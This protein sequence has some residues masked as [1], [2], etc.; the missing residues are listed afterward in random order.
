MRG[1]IVSRQSRNTFPQAAQQLAFWRNHA[2]VWQ[3]QRLG[4]IAP[5]HDSSLH[6]HKAFEQ[7]T[8]MFF[9][10]GEQLT[11]Q[12]LRLLSKQDRRELWPWI[13]LPD[14]LDMSIAE[15][16]RNADGGHAVT[17]QQNRGLR[18][19][20]HPA[21]RSC[22]HPPRLQNQNATRCGGTDL[23]D[24]QKQPARSTL[25]GCLARCAL[26]RRAVR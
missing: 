2:A 4:S 13:G 8:G 17:F 19:A 1:F 23:S 22:S 18:F 10:R 9:G 11:Q 25:A 3:F 7:V 5:Q 24:A 12:T 20:L 16:A 14:A 21:D 15:K 6:P 26:R